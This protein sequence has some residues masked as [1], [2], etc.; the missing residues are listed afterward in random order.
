MGKLKGELS[1]RNSYWIDRHRHRTE[2]REV[3]YTEGREDEICCVC[4]FSEYP[5]CK[6]FCHNFNKNGR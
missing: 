4:G 2:E 1:Q 6:S 3:P 5:E